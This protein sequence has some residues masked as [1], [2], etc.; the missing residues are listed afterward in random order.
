MKILADLVKELQPEFLCG[1]S[2]VPVLAVV[3]DS[4]KITEGCLFIAI[5][6]ANF[7]GHSAL[8][9][10]AGKK[11]AAVLV[12]EIDA[13]TLSLCETNGV[14]VV[15]T[16][17]TRYGLGLVSAA[18]FDMPAKKLVTVGIT[19]TKGKTTTTYLI[20]SMLENAGVKCGLIGTIEADNG[21]ERIPAVNTTPESY[22]VQ[23]YFA[24]MAENGCRAVVM[25]VSSQALMMHRVAGITFDIGVFTNLSPDHIGPNEHKDFDEYLH[26]KSLLFRQC[27]VGLVNGDDPYT[28]QIL[29]GNSCETVERYGFSEK[30]D[31]RP[32][33]KRC[34]RS[35]GR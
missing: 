2:E 1:T 16:G 17:N 31:Y 9:Q 24:Q 21:K 4:R 15:K 10:A 13:G 3:Y 11:A 23:Q 27:R 32:A 28:E 26:C 8:P 20:K 25:E 7:D 6:G 33:E 18:W 34:C 30:N 19:G 29:A 5:R 14:T 12:E 22:L 35:R